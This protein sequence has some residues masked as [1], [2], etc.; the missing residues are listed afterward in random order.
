MNTIFD[1]NQTI[2][3]DAYLKRIKTMIFEL[4]NKLFHYKELFAKNNQISKLEIVLNKTKE[5]IE[6]IELEFNRQ[7]FQNH[8]SF[9]PFPNCN[10]NP[11]T[12]I[13]ND[14]SPQRRIRA[15]TISGSPPDTGQAVGAK[16]LEN[17]IQRMQTAKNNKKIKTVFE[18]GFNGEFAPDALV[19]LNRT[20]EQF[21]IQYDLESERKNID[22][23]NKFI[24]EF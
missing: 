24:D 9:T 1:Y 16:I 6:K 20:K 2:I 21:H 13:V 22:S 23:I 14:I 5:E 4:N 17:G 7:K 8:M 12:F 11:N 3:E 15:R 10:I 18:T 19:N